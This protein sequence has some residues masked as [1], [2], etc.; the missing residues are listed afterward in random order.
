MEGRAL[1]DTLDHVVGQLHT[2]SG[3][4]TTV[5]GARAR[6]ASQPTGAVAGCAVL[7]SVARLGGQ[8]GA[9]RTGCGT[10]VIADDKVGA[11]HA[12]RGTRAAT[13]AGTLRVTQL[14]HFI[15]V[16]VLVRPT[17]IG[18]F[19]AV[20]LRLD[21]VKTGDAVVG[22]RPRAP[23]ALGVAGH[24]GCAVGQREFPS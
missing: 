15:G 22:G 17:A 14:A 23:V 24:T 13:A 16:G 2:Q 20:G 21:V 10:R 5:D 11:V 1:V 9:R 19:G 8:I 4:V 7:A 12:K 18:A 6:A 3:A